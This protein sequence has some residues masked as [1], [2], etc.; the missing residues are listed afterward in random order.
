MFPLPGVVLFPRVMIPL[1]VYELRY[2]ALVRDALAT[3][4]RFALAPLRPGWEREYHGSPAFHDLGCIATIEQAE[5]LPDDRY[6]LRVVGTTRARFT[7][8]VREFPYRE[9]L[10]ETL[11]QVPHDSADP[12]AVLERQALLER[13]A[14]LA[15]AGAAAWIASPRLA[16][17]ADVETVVNELAFAARLDVE[18][19]LELLAMDSVIDRGR[20]LRERLDRLVAGLAG[21]RGDAE[22]P[23]GGELN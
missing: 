3:D 10:A 1:H 22:E 8:V 21:G 9:V 16:D 17:E 20:R 6:D 23:P 4:R 13:H 2:R 14:K 11:P 12:L 18:Q 7:R 15:G 19:K 5:W